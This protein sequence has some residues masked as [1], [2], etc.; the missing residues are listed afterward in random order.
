[1]ITLNI[2]TAK[3]DKTAIYEGKTGKFL[4]L[5]LMEN[6]DGPDQYGNDGFIIQ[7]IG[8]ER[9]EAGERGPIVGNYKNRDRKPD[10][11]QRQAPP[12]DAHNRAKADGFA[13]AKDDDGSIP[14]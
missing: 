6:R 3:I 9:R 8:K 12:Q 10:G 5:T 1:M 4:N 13:P 2:N 11:Y 14:F 7:D